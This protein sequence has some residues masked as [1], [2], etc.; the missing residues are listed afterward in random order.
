[1]AETKTRNKRAKSKTIESAID[2]AL[3]KLRSGTV[4][5]ARA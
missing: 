3:A 5:S 2:T 4:R 1:V